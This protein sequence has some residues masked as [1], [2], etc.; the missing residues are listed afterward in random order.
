MK[1]ILSLIAGAS[2]LA[3]ASGASA[4]DPVKL[5]DGQ[6]DRVTAGYAV[7]YNGT[8]YGDSVGLGVANLITITKTATL[9]I[10]DPANTQPV[11]P[12]G[13]GCGAPCA[14]AAGVSAVGSVSVWTPGLPLNNAA[15]VSTSAA[16]AALY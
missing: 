1:T 6:M 15:A 10:S 13:L 11:P 2:M 3:V 12:N 8:A 4:Q 14:Y 5:S 16:S 7:V 9:A